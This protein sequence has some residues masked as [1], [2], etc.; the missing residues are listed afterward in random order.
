M[1]ILFLSHYYPPE[2]NAPATRTFDHCVRWAEAGHE[3]TVVTCAPNCPDGVLYPGY[4]NS[5]LPQVD[6]R[7][8]VRSVRVWTYLA[9]NTGTVRRIV[10][11]LSYIVGAVLAS[12]WLP[13]PDVVV[14]TSPQFFCGWA[15]VLVSRIRRVPL[16][17]E[18]SKGI[19][20]MA[21]LGPSP[22]NLGEIVIKTS[23]AEVEQ[24]RLF[25]KFVVEP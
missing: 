7:K 19:R 3:V 5:L 16:V 9:A 4:K 25:V 8:G 14:A 13:R 2:V 6:Y 18:I 15:G 23:N 17:L 11:Y 22:S 24:L 12:L 1:R 10:N 21:H 20:N